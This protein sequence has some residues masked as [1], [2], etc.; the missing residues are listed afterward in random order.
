MQEEYRPSFWIFLEKRYL[1]KTLQ[2][3]GRGRAFHCKF[4]ALAGGDESMLS[5][6][7]M[8]SPSA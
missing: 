2:G 1:V 3:G 4:C 6:Q 5:P 7:I 8:R